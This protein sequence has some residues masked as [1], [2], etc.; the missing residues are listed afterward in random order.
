MKAIV[1]LSGG[2]DSTTTLYYA[3]NRGYQCYALSFDYDQRHKKE[4]KIAR[5][6]AKGAK[7]P[8]Q[9][10]KIKLPWKGS[11]LLDKKIAIPSRRTLKKMAQEIPVT[12]V[13]ARNTIFLSFALSYAEAVGPK[14]SLSVRTRSIT[15]AIPI[16][17]PTITGPTKK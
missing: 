8:W 13:P 4:V 10:L 17:V 12:Y 2:L 14:R 11:A 5:A 9:V 16:V 6:I 7:V 1:L 3:L 15:P